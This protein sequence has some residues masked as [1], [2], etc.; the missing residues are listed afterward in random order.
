M[1]GLMHT[2]FLGL[3]TVGF[4]A[5]WGL[6]TR[7]GTAQALGTVKASGILPDGSPL[8]RVYTFIPSLDKFLLSPVIFYD[9]LMCHSSP[10]YRSLLVSL[11]GTMQ[12]TAFCM[13]V[14]SFRHG[15]QSLGA[16]LESF[17]WGVWNQSYG[18][19]FV[20]PVYFLTHAREA[21]NDSDTLNDISRE[22][23][24]A[25]LYTSVVAALI[26][27][28]L[29]YP[30]FFPCSSNTRQALIASYRATPAILALAQPITA[31]LLRRF[32]STLLPNYSPRQVVKISL[33]VSGTSAALSHFYALTSSLL[34]S[35]ITPRS[36]FWPGATDVKGSVGRIIAQGC[37][38][39]LQNDWW[40]ISAAIIPFTF[41]MLRSTRRRKEKVGSSSLGTWIDRK[42]GS[43][44]NTGIL[45]L[46]GLTLVFSPG[47]TLAWSMA[48]RI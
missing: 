2:Y 14:N 17:A 15:K 10:T 19:A 31:S 39:F 30:A 16:V 38:L 33:L 13:I 20:Y 43:L 37:H 5:L 26:P 3:A 47:A 18:A 4:D 34:S 41:V 29:L 1:G 48:T 40:I 21:S 44:S 32:C 35:R 9:A 36:V 23:A 45:G 8:N 11:F 22:D 24:E 7:N 42:L 25:L 6:M 12:T 28:W 46:S 27:A